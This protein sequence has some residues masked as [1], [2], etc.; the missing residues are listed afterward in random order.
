MTPKGKYLFPEIH[1]SQY[2]ESHRRRN[3]FLPRN[4]KAKSTDERLKGESQDHAHKII[5][6]WAE[7]ES[8]GKLEKRKETE[9][10]GEF[11]TEI[12]GEALGT[13]VGVSVAGGE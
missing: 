12:F 10:E 2:G 4:L 9:L 6:K 5:L 7:M 13:R 3:L 1:P 11:I 8:S